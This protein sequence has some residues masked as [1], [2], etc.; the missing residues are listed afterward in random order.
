MAMAPRRGLREDHGLLPLA[1]CE[2]GR[3]FQLAAGQ[4]AL[5]LQQPDFLNP[6]L[7]ERKIVV[8]PE[9]VAAIHARRKHVTIKLLE[10][11][12]CSA[13]RLASPY[14]P[15]VHVAPA[16]NEHGY[17]AAIGSHLDFDF[18]RQATIGDDGLCPIVR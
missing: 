11:R 7:E 5:G 12:E 16:L 2:I 15:R 1:G 9:M 14:L 18:L 6:R 8:R 4:C 3:Q 13:K 10:I 17:G